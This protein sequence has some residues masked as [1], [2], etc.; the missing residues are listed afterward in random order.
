MRHLMRKFLEDV[1]LV[2]PD[3][4][5]KETVTLQEVDTMYDQAA[6][7]FFARVACYADQTQRTRDNLSLGKTDPLIQQ[8][9]TLA[10]KSR[11]IPAAGAQLRLRIA[12]TR[13]QIGQSQTKGRS[14]CMQLMG[15]SK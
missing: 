1:D 9:T 7:P 10:K 14:R 11:N 12:E 3:F 4:R 6:P 2:D 15:S 13:D 8:W 5:Q